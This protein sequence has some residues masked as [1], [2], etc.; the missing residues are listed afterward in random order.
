MRRCVSSSGWA[1]YS[2]ATFDLRSNAL[3][4]LGWTSADAAGLAILPGLV[5]F[6]EVADGSINHAIRVTMSATQRAY[7]LPATH[8]HHPAPM[9]TCR[10]WVCACD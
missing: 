7:I 3:R 8:A 1:A 2:G 5:R 10:R 4:P 6:D 9:P